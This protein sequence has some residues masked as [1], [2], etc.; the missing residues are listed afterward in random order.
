MPILAPEPEM[1]PDRLLELPL[2]VCPWRVA[3][4]RSRQ[5]KLLARHLR[6]RGVGYYLPQRPGGSPARPSFS[7]LFPGYVFFRSD[8]SGRV[9][10]LKS[11][12]IVAILDVF[13]QARLHEELSQLASLLAA[14]LPVE[15]HPY[16]EIGEEIRVAGGPFDGYRGVVVRERGAGRFIISISLLRKSVAVELDA[17]RLRPVSPLRPSRKAALAVG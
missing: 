8:E 2:P 5:E 14:G 6:G 17:A 10:A 11:N 13:D 4:V 7:P 12:V 16:V 1:A 3:R 15:D 9:E